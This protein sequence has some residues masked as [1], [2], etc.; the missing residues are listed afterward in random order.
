MVSCVGNSQ[1]PGV[2]AGVTVWCGYRHSG[3]SEEQVTKRRRQLSLASVGPS[4]LLQLRDR[5]S[6]GQQESTHQR[7]SHCPEARDRG[8]NGRYREI[9][10][11]GSRPS[12][13]TCIRLRDSLNH[14]EGTGPG[15]IL[16]LHALAW[17][18]CRLPHRTTV[19]KAGKQLRLDHTSPNDIIQWPPSRWQ[20]DLGRVHLDAGA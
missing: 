18:S 8:G 13:N 5:A 15:L 20:W 9:E 6:E 1:Q 7:G 16:S 10:G 3:C 4:G 14:S 2:D 12:P 11:E 19:P 17:C